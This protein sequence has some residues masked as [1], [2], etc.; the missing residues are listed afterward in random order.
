MSEMF[1]K[2]VGSFLRAG[3]LVLVPFLE[4]SGIWTPEQSEEFVAWLVAGGVAIGW[5]LWEKYRSQILL[6]LALNSPAGTTV[7]EVKQKAADPSEVR[8]LLSVLLLVGLVGFSAACATRN[9]V[10]VSPEG[11]LALRANQLVQALRTLTVPPGSSPVEQLVA[12]KTITVNEALVV[13]NVVK[14]TMVYAQDL[15]TVL[16]VVDEART[17]AERETGLRRAAVLVENVRK[18]LASATLNVGTEAGRKAVLNVLLIAS[19]ILQTV[20]SVLPV[21]APA[22]AGI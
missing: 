5:S 3:L 1:S 12:S 2:F 8:R 7:A 14:E 21:P 11:T 15:A 10:Q 22:P 13:A 9:G 18:S 19:Q 6:A 17:E 16:K 4:K 20:G